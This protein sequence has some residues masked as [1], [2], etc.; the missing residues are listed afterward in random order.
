MVSSIQMVADYTLTAADYPLVTFQR[1]A[2]K[3]LAT[4]SQ[5]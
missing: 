1:P 5:L 2:H 4:I 3:V